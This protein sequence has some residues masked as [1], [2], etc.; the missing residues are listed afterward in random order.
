MRPHS[1]RFRNGGEAGRLAVQLV[2]QCKE[3]RGGKVQPVPA[4]KEFLIE[5]R[6]DDDTHYSAALSRPYTRSGVIGSS[7]I[8]TPVAAVTELPTAASGGTIGTSPTP[9]TP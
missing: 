1:A 5:R 4:T 7:C 9:L 2:H 6:H 8:R 3:R